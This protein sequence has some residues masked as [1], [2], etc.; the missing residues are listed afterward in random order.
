[1]DTDRA[2]GRCDLCGLRLAGFE[3]MGLVT[4]G[5]LGFAPTL[6]RRLARLFNSIRPSLVH[7]R[8]HRVRSVGGSLYQFSRS[9]ELMFD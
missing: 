7:R 4:G 2:L 1:M 5:G 9:Q 6:G 8:M 3:K